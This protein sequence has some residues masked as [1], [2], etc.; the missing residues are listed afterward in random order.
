MIATSKLYPI[1]ADQVSGIESVKA[2]GLN[3]QL[4]E[5]ACYQTFLVVVREI[6]LHKTD[7][8]QGLARQH[9]HGRNENPSP[10]NNWGQFVTGARTY[11]LVLRYIKLRDLWGWCIKYFQ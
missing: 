6:L 11:R 4:P 10:E 2:M 7:Q 3:L 1:Q 5:R 9:T 8:P